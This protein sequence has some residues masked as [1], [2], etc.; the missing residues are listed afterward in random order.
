L[1][2]ENNSSPEEMNNDYL[3]IHLVAN[4]TISAPLWKTQTSESV[5]DVTKTVLCVE[6]IRLDNSEAG[7]E[8]ERE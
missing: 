3:A 4:W 1:R 8:T 5:D 6:A 2:N 7:R